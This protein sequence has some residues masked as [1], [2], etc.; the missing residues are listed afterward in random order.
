M[1]KLKVFMQCSIGGA[2]QLFMRTVKNCDVLVH[3]AIV[4]SEKI[5]QLVDN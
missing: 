1:L 5:W 4:T 3:G 2:M